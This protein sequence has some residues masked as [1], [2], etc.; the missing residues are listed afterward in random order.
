MADSDI[1]IE[2]ILLANFRFSFSESCASSK[3]M[4]INMRN[5]RDQVRNMQKVEQ[6]QAAASKQ[7]QLQVI[8]TL[9]E[10]QMNVSQRT[11][12]H[13]HTQAHTYSTFARHVQC[14]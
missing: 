9:C 4:Q 3:L 12:T 7:Q 13:P 5:V 1:L 8:I 11:P 10:F 6:L 14:L 2:L